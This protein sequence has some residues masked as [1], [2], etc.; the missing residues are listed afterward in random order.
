MRKDTSQNNLLENYLFDVNII[1]EIYMTLSK[2]KIEINGKNY[3]QYTHDVIYFENSKYYVVIYSVNK[4]TILTVIENETTLNCQ[5]LFTTDDVIE[6]LK[7]ED[8]TNYLDYE[9]A[10]LILEYFN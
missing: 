9:V 3:E 6:N 7:I 2:D 1:D 10:D 8:F 5:I 4:N